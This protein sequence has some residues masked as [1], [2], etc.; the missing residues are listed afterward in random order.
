VS[1]E[2]YPD[3]PDRLLTPAEQMQFANLVVWPAI[4]HLHGR[5]FRLHAEV[6][7]S[8]RLR[9][10][11]VNI[12]DDSGRMRITVEAASPNSKSVINDQG[13]AEVACWTQVSISR[14]FPDLKE[15]VIALFETE[16]PDDEEDDDEE[17]DD[18]EDENGDTE[19]TGQWWKDE[20]FDWQVWEVKTF[21]FTND[22][23]QPFLTYSELE[24]HK[25][26][27]DEEFFLW[28]FNS[29]DASPARTGMDRILALRRTEFE[30]MLSYGEC[31]EI[32]AAL[33]NLGVPA[34]VMA[35][36]V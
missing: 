33:L 35:E 23:K 34:T 2:S 31:M 21:D 7:R 20:D 30:S 27:E 14:L 8:L 1:K 22:V 3:T 24:I 19:E 10:Q 6:R 5:D 36:I 18:E 29:P 16:P 12:I 4:D 32:R 15:G 13:E 9:P 25:E 28:T 17:D 26:D 11:T